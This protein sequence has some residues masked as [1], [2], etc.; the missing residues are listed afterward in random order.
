MAID[1][2]DNIELSSRPDSD[3]HTLGL[4][5][6]RLVA[7]EHLGGLLKRLVIFRTLSARCKADNPLLQVLAESK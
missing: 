1:V 5:E 6:P 7:D 3:P 2:R 4:R